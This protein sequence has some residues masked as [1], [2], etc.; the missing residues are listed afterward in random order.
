MVLWLNPTKA[1]ALEGKA[2]RESRADFYI[3]GYTFSFMFLYRSF[4]GGISGVLCISKGTKLEGVLL[5]WI[6][7]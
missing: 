7:I 6:L 1:V 2:G 3:P 4:E 5:S